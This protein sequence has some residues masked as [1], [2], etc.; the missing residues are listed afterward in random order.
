MDQ[1]QAPQNGTCD[2][3]NNTEIGIAYRDQ[4]YLVLWVA[5]FFFFVF[6]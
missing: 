2:I 4:I 5:S 6:L 3:F 1:G